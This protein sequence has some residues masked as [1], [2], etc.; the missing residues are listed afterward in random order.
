MIVIHKQSWGKYFLFVFGFTPAF[1]L[2][3]V[4]KSIT[5]FIFIFCD[6]FCMVKTAYA[7]IDFL[8]WWTHIRNLL[9]LKNLVV[10]FL[11]MYFGNSLYWQRWHLNFW[12]YLNDL[13]LFAFFEQSHIMS[14]RCG[15]FKIW[16]INVPSWNLLLPIGKET[17]LFLSTVDTQLALV[18]LFQETLRLPVRRKRGKFVCCI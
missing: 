9:Q 5:I 4:F 18:L 14:S 13:W 10:S 2:N 11:L 3:A 17:T 12:D 1:I 16:L 15:F 8:D 7:F 6:A